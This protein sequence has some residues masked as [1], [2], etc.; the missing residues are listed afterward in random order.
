MVGID[1]LYERLTDLD[2]I[3]TIEGDVSVFAN[4]GQIIHRINADLMSSFSDNLFPYLSA[5][6]LVSTSIMTLIVLIVGLAIA[7]L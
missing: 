5:R 1:S 7:V 2:L 3:R 4:V 6:S